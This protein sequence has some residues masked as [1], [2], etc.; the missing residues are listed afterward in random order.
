MAKLGE[1]EAHILDFIVRDYVRS[2]LPVSSGRICEAGEFEV[3]PATIR[4][5]MLELETEGFLEKPHTSAGRVPTDKAYRY[6]VDFLMERREPQRKEK[7]I[8]AGLREDPFENFGRALAEHLG[9]FTAVAAFGSAGWR[10]T[11][12][13]GF[14]FEEV[15]RE[16][17]FEDHDLSLEFARLVDRLDKSAE[18]CL[19]RSERARPAA[20]IGAENDFSPA[21]RF[22]TV[23]LKF[24]NDK[25]GNVVIFSIGPKRMNYERVFAVLNQE[26]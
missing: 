1:R 8:F 19:K 18:I 23:S 14:G 13:V 26:L 22:S 20:F 15:M 24:K 16:P 2:A 4:N 7:E 25:I 3:S 12:A 11:R 21:S 10:R 17:E 6:F 5:A 9:L